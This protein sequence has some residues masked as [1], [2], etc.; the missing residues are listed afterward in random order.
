MPVWGNTQWV[1]TNSEEKQSR[2][3]GRIVGGDDGEGDS[4]W[5]VSE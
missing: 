5:A 1:P 4:E 3:G 2:K